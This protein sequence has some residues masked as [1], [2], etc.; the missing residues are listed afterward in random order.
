MIYVDVCLNKIGN[1][2]LYCTSIMIYVT[3]LH[4]VV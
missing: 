1:A 3:A 4:D 2:A